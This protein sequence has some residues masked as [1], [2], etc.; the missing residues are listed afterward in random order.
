VVFQRR[1]CGALRL[2]A[3]P[4]VVWSFRPRCRTDKESRLLP[5]QW[6]VCVLLGF[7]YIDRTVVFEF[8][9]GGQLF[10]SGVLPLRHAYHGGIR[11]SPRFLLGHIVSSAK[12]WRAGENGGKGLAGRRRQVRLRPGRQE[13]VRKGVRVERNLVTAISTTVANEHTVRAEPQTCMRNSLVTKQPRHP[14][15]SAPWRGSN[16]CGENGKLAECVDTEMVIWPAASG[17]YS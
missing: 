9:R 8:C 16:V 11:S 2:V 5:Q 7:Y 1:R 3:V 14:I 6:P 4:T 12:R 10:R 13:T 17:G 15:L